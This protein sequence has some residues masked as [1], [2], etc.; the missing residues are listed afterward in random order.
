MNKSHKSVRACLLCLLMILTLF[1]AQVWAID[2]IDLNRE[3]SMVV[4]YEYDGIR[5][6]G[7]EFRI[8]RVAD[9]DRFAVLS[10]SGDFA[11]NG[12]MIREL[13][14]T[15]EWDTLAQELTAFVQESSI[16][17]LRTGTVSED[18][19]CRFENLSVGLYL[20]VGD[21]WKIGKTTY[22]CNPFLVCLPYRID[23]AEN[24]T[25]DNV[26][27]K[28]KAGEPSTEPTPPPEE[29]PY[30]PNTGMLWWPVPILLSAGMLFVLGGLVRKRENAI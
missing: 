13:K 12:Q 6:A 19:T 1:P 8:Y 3:T 11:G 24:W 9:M 22:T 15:E 28:P 7:A 29:P 27:V 30:L 16:Q 23:N 25:Y 5:L 14:S 4:T 20:V 10:P 26:P 21:A 17:P 18:G 2:S